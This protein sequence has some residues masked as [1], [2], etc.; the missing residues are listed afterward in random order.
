MLRV[1]AEMNLAETAFVV[2][3]HGEFDL[4]W[5]TPTVEMKL[6]GHATLATAHVLWETERLA[7][8]LPAR[9]HTKSGLLVCTR[10]GDSIEMDFPAVVASAATAPPGLEAALGVKAIWVGTNEFDYLVEVATEAEV[11][12]VSPDL[13]ALAKLPKRGVIVTAR[14]TTP[15]FDFVSRFF[16]PAVGVP[17]DPVTGSAHCAL[18]PYWAAKL[19]KTS[20]VGRQLSPRGGTVHVSLKGDRVILGGK[21]ITMLRGQLTE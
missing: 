17:E 3:R 9:F 20:L 1:A 8:T 19:G 10:Q 14:A 16:A 11:K 18:A 7:H 21:A 2:P 6:C 4:Q 15:G 12:N 13:A 5:F